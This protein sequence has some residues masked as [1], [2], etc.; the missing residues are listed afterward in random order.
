MRPERRGGIWQVTHLLAR[1][2]QLL[3]GAAVLVEALS[4]AT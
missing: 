4:R 3:V 2:G 1:L